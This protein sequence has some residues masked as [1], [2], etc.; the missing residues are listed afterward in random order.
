MVIKS[1]WAK[2]AYIKSCTYFLLKSLSHFGVT[3]TLNYIYAIGRLSV[4]LYFPKSKA[5]RGSH[6]YLCHTELHYRTHRKVFGGRSHRTSSCIKKRGNWTGAF[7]RSHMQL[8]IY[9][10]D[11]LEMLF[12]HPNS[13]DW[14]TVV[15]PT[16]FLQSSISKYAFQLQRH[17][18]RHQKQQCASQ[19]P[20][21]VCCARMTNN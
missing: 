18:E 9:M 16:C 1:Y 15:K 19:P 4:S 3:F 20:N 14:S 10:L 7:T 5:I 17:L 8:L 2:R 6:C 21:N 12:Q 13:S 11:P